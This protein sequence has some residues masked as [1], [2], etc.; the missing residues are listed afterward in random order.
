MCPS[1]KSTVRCL[2]TPDKHPA[3]FQAYD[4][5]FVGES[6]VVVTNHDAQQLHDDFD[7]D[8]CGS[9]RWEYLDEG[10]DTWRVRITKLATTPLPRILCNTTGVVRG[11]HAGT[12]GVRWKLHMRR[13]DLDSNIIRLPPSACIGAHVGPEVDVLLLVLDEQARSPP[14]SASSMC[15]PEHSS[16]CP[17]V[18]GASSPPGHTGSA[19]SPSTHAA[20]P[21]SSPLPHQPSNKLI[22]PLR[23]RPWWM[24]LWVSRAL[25]SVSAATRSVAW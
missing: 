2:P 11:S 16:G 23:G 6:F 17:N 8:H 14:S 7:A 25:T 9:Y 19:T 24:K 4:A 5:L 13:R 3:I 1:W 10:P 20:S 15:T 22:C 12:T 18:P 21:C